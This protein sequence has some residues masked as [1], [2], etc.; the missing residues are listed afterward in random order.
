MLIQSEILNIIYWQKLIEIKFS[1][2]DGVYDP[3]LNQSI[4]EMGIPPMAIHGSR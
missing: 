1:P 3:L 2:V 4:W